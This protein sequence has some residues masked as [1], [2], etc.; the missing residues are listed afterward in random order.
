MKKIATLL[1]LLALAFAFSACGDDDDDNDNPS[2]QSDLI[3]VWNFEKATVDKI[4][5]NN[6]EIKQALDES[7]KLLNYENTKMSLTFRVDGT[8]VIRTID[9]AD[10]GKYTV[11]GNKV[12]LTSDGETMTCIVKGNRMTLTESIPGSQ[13]EEDLGV[14]IPS[15]VLKSITLSIHFVK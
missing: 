14:S 13:L 10:K 11:N 1:C 3:G 7:F 9:D 2:S 12:L 5:P 6:N 4:Q 15:E 8:F